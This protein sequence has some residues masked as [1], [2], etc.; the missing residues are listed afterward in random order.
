MA[1]RDFKGVWIPKEVWLDKRLSMLD[2]GILAEIDS[3]DMSEDGC[4]ASNEYLAEFCQ[5]SPTKVSTSISRLV[6]LG[7][8][9]IAS[10]D[11][12]KRYLKSCLSKSESLPF[13]NCKA[14]FQKVK[15]SNIDNNTDRKDISSTDDVPDGFD[16]FWKEY[17]RKDGKQDAIKAWR[18]LNPGKQLQDTI[19]K[20][21]QRRIHE[22]GSWFN[23]ERRFIKMAAS[24]LRGRRWEDETE[25]PRRDE[26]D[27][28]PFTQPPSVSPAEREAMH[29]ALRNGTFFQKYKG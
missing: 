29:E 22:G 13:K 1:D 28:L 17:P 16:I 12:R 3:L 6:E 7:Y 14:A 26:G 8:I 11:G 19:R 10:F 15:D 9:R 5:C 23:T 27:H 25:T 24:Y 4:F 20:D 18:S 21:V 2:K